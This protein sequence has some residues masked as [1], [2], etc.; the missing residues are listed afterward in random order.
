MKYFLLL[1][2]LFC[3]CGGIGATNNMFTDIKEIEQR[4]GMN[5]GDGA[6][7]LFQEDNLGGD[8]EAQSWLIFMKSRSEF[9]KG[10]LEPQTANDAQEYFGRFQ[11]LA[12]EDIGALRSE[13][14]TTAFW[15]RPDGRYDAAVIET[16][17]G[18]IMELQWVKQN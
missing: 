11:R 3:A 7:V 18:F 4:S 16:D 5:F 6:K 13:Q 2:V 9:P 15:E 17:K 1:T 8:Q 10:K 14:T 12:S